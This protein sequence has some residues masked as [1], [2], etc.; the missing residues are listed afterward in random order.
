MGAFGAA[1]VETRLDVEGRPDVLAEA[2]LAAD[3]C[4]DEDCCGSVM[5]KQ[6]YL[7]RCFPRIS[8][9]AQLVCW[10]RKAGTLKRDEV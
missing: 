6:W 10:C 7:P 2:C 4:A 1:T 9:D 5:T 3:G 8:T